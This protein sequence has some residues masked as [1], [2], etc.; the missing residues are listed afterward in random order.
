MRNGEVNTMRRATS[1][2][3][4]EPTENE[5]WKMERD[6]KRMRMAKRKNRGRYKNQQRKHSR[7][8]MTPS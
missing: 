6:R 5:G 4:T 8:R 1:I 7:A 2:L 3:P